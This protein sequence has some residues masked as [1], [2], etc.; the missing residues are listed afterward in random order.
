MSSKAVKIP[1]VL[2]CLLALTV[3]SPAKSAAGET[4]T[5]SPTTPPADAFV[6]TEVNPTNLTIGETA[7]VSVKLNNIPVE[8]YKS[9]EFTCTYNAGLVEKSNIVATDLF[10]ADPVVAIHDPQTGT[11]IVAIA[12]ANSNRATT[13]GTAFTF[14]ANGLQAGQSQIQCTARVSTGDNLSIGV[15]S[16]GADLTILAA[17]V[18]PTP[19]ESPTSTP[20]DSQ[21]PTPT[22]IAP[23]LPTSVPSPYGFISGQVIARKP[24]A[25]SL[26]DA[27]NMTT[28]SVVANPDGTFSLTALAGNY[29]LLATASGFLSRQGSASITAGNTT[30]KPA[31]DLLAGDVNGNNVID[32]FDVLTIG[33][34]YRSST[35]EA[36]DLNND[37]VID[38]LDLELLAENYRQTGPSVWE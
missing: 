23:E 31:V 17:D 5:P 25:I 7:L 30:V 26:L 33:M 29:T 37:G 18:S 35:P 2:L 38:F 27:N 15:P 20:S 9:A 8:G 16:I 34:N 12:G 19:F 4:P 11:F 1:I 22:S 21:Y 14:S 13:S 6:S 32:Q 10:G 24:V 36:A 28:T 3:P